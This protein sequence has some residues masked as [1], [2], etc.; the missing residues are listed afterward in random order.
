MRL[1]GAPQ[2]VRARR[3]RAQGGGLRQCH[4]G[5]QARRRG[6]GG[7]GALPSPRGALRARLHPRQPPPGQREGQRREQGRL[8]QEEPLAPVPSLHDVGALNRRLPD[9]RLGPS[10]GKRRY[11]LGTPEPELFGEGRG[12]S[13][14]CPRRR[15]RARGGRP[16][17]AAGRGR[18]PSAGRAAARPAPPARAARPPSRSA[19]STSRSSTARPGRSSPPTSAS[20][21]RPPP[22]ARTRRCG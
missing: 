8:P 21:A 7:L 11:R 20:G 17:G 4:R 15:S 10:E 12:R 19:P 9:D 3:R 18:S 14:R 22:T 6:G 13:R 16:G 1:P 2:R 5:R